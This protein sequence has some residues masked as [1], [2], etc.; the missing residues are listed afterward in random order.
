M[1]ASIIIKKKLRSHPKKLQFQWYPI[2]K[3]FKLMDQSAKY[4]ETK[5]KKK[6]AM[7]SCELD[8]CITSI[9]LYIKKWMTCY[10]SFNFFKKNKH[11]Q[12]KIIQ[13]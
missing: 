4:R 6:Q 9:F 5:K 11:L 10:L 8:T 2:K 12:C 7:Q 3:N 1:L 13:Q